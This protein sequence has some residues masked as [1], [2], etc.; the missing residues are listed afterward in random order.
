MNDAIAWVKIFMTAIGAGMV[1]AAQ[2]VEPSEAVW[3]MAVAGGLLGVALGEDGSITTI[4]K[5]VVLGIVVAIAAAAL[6]EFLFRI[7]RVPVA[8]FAGL[9]AARMT[10]AI[11]KQI[12][13]DGPSVLLPRWFR[14]GL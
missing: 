5:H 11:N 3:I 6:A 10:V 9:F 4:L 2:T 12:D 8:L 14:K 1:A 13:T 7:P